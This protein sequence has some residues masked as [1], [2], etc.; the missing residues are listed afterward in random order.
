MIACPTWRWV[1][2]RCEPAIRLERLA[3]A[4]THRSWSEGSLKQARERACFRGDCVS[5]RPAVLSWFLQI[6]RSLGRFADH[7]S[8]LQKQNGPRAEANPEG[9]RKELLAGLETAI[10]RG[11]MRVRA[12]ASEDPRSH[13]R[14]VKALANLSRRIAG[15]HRDHTQRHVGRRSS[16]RNSFRLRKLCRYTFAAP[17]APTPQ[18]DASVL[19]ALFPIV[20]PLG[21]APLFLSLTR[22]Y[23]GISG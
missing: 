19:T 1:W 21:S 18:V 8:A 20:N 2:S 5:S 16:R 15:S 14:W 22:Y 7:A 10:S 3:S 9:T 11:S 13:E 4:L 17:Y 12:L 23:T 6:C